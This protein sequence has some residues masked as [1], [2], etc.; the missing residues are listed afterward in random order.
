MDKY[1]H[2][3]ID[4]QQITNR[5]E[6]STKIQQYWQKHNYRT[7]LKTTKTKKTNKIAQTK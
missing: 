4:L 5:T 2:I 1:E 7:K 3:K 6:D